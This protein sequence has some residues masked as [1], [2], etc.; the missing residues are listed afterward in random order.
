[1]EEFKRENKAETMKNIDKWKVEEVITDEEY[2]KRFTKP[3]GN[4]M[5]Y[6]NIW[7]SIQ[8]K[9]KKKI[10]VVVAE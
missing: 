1:M 5:N 9:G 6:S 8:N 7:S 4:L 3:D 2:F 10:K